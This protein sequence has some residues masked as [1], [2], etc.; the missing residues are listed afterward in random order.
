[1]YEI[2]REVEKW[3]VEPGP[4]PPLRGHGFF[5]RSPSF[6]RLSCDTTRRRGAPAL[7]PHWLFRS[8]SVCVRARLIIYFFPPFS[9]YI[10]FL[11]FLSLEVHRERERIERNFFFF[12]CIFSFFPL[13]RS[14]QVTWRAFGPELRA[15]TCVSHASVSLLLSGSAL[16]QQVH[17]RIIHPLVIGEM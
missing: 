10:L 17:G 14:N 11:F 1:M 7:R 9:F 6:N 16:A 15:V 12:C 4:G 13:F 5:S 3:A 2:H 8:L